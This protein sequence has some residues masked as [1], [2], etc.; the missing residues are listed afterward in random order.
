MAEW[1]HC[2]VP[3]CWVMVPCA[4]EP[5]R[6]HLLAK[7]HV[8]PSAMKAIYPSLPSDQR[9]SSRTS[10]RKKRATWIAVAVVV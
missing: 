2:A 9:F 8:L 4:A 6:S 1:L 10:T 3:P 5:E 7:G